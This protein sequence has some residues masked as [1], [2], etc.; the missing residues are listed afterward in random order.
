MLPSLLLNRVYDWTRQSLQDVALHQACFSTVRLRSSTFESKKT[1][2][3][4]ST[5]VDPGER[6]TL[7]Q[8]QPKLSPPSRRIPN[9]QEG[10]DREKY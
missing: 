4:L 3:A 5:S 2:A 7:A 9:L 8:E 6:S 10:K 1:R